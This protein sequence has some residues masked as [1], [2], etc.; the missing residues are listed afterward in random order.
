[1]DLH[2]KYDKY[3]GEEAKKYCEDL[4][5]EDKINWHI[6]SMSEYKSILSTKPY[7]GFVIDGIPKYYMD[8]KDFK[9]MTPSSY[10]TKTK[11]GSMAYQSI[12]RNKVYKKREN[13][14]YHIRC[15]HTKR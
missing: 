13:T 14:K 7:K 15:V 11:D 4:I 8:P 5:L 9:N 3:S 12:S 1:M 6:P 2:P 10:W